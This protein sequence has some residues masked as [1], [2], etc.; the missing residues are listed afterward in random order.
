[1]ATDLTINYAKFAPL[2]NV[3]TFAPYMSLLC[4]ANFDPLNI[5]SSISD[6][7]VVWLG[8]FLL[9]PEF[10]EGGYYYHNLKQQPLENNC[11]IPPHHA[12]AKTIGRQERCQIVGAIL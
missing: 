3:W 4:Y 1:M 11:G 8:Q 7:L 12:R 9:A 2:L 6:T 10:V 5:L